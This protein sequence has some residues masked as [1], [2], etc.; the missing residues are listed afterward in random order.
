MLHRLMKT[1]IVED[2]VLFRELVTKVCV[3][4]FNLLVVAATGSGEEALELIAEKRPGL[5]VLDLALPDVDGFA[6][7]EKARGLLGDLKIL[8]VS[9]RL[10]E[11]SVSRIEH[12]GVDGFVD[13][14][15]SSIAVL[16]DALATILSGG[17]YFSEEFCVRRADR[18]ESSKSIEKLLSERE[19]EVLELIGAGASDIEVGVRLHISTETAR[20]H[21]R[22][23]S[24]KL[25]TTGIR[26]LMTFAL[27]HGF[28][29]N[30]SDTIAPR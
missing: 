25:G 5:L 13:K 12:L 1:I 7:A 19:Q 22:H 27:Q 3:E 6:V 21:R 11:H 28:P 24:C 16:K 8:I 29:I 17:R 9:C 20:N 14:N 10:D 4:E 23:I 15:T 30:K 26:D 2:H 18:W